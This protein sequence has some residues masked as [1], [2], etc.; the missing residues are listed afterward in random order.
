MK[1]LK[2]TFISTKKV[3]LDIRAKDRKKEKSIRKSILDILATTYGI[4]TS[5]Y[6]GGDMEGPSI[7]K[8]ETKGR[9]AFKNIAKYL[10]SINQSENF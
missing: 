9:K 7:R 8:F 10:L 3:E 1:H 4:H 6:H 2:Q 5:S